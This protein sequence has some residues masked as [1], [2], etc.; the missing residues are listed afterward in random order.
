[1]LVPLANGSEEIESMSIIGTMVRAQANVVIAKVFEQD[2]DQNDLK[3]V[4]SRGVKVIAD[5]PIHDS[6]GKI[7]LIYFAKI[8]L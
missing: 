5:A 6:M 4:L 7:A 3:L 1:M 2:E 8:D